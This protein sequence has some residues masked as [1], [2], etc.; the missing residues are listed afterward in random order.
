MLQRARGEAGVC[1]CR[2]KGNVEVRR[3]GT[4]ILW[5]AVSAG[6]R[7][8]HRRITR[9]RGP[10]FAS[11]QTGL[12]FG[13]S[14]IDRRWPTT[15]STACRRV[16]APVHLPHPRSTTHLPASFFILPAMSSS[17]LPS[18]GSKVRARLTVIRLLQADFSSASRPSEAASF[19]ARSFASSSPNP[20]FPPKQD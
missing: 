14:S 10:V 5:L 16:A 2:L 3:V 7:L 9:A 12:W 18:K 6:S 11:V 1:V 8:S 13:F 15:A 20:A 4:T 19:S 17:S